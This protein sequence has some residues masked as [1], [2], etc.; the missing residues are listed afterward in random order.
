M[1]RQRYSKKESWNRILRRFQG[2]GVVGD[3]PGTVPGEILSEDE[4]WSDLAELFAGSLPNERVRTPWAEYGEIYVASGTAELGM[5]ENQWENI[6]I[7][8]TAGISSAN[9]TPSPSGNYVN[10]ND[11]G[12]YFVHYQAS[13]YM[14]VEGR[15]LDWRA[16]WNMTGQDQTRSRIYVGTSG[17]VHTVSA[18]GLVDVTANPSYSTYVDLYAWCENATGTL[19]ILDA[20]LSVWK[21]K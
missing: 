2:K 1:T 14:D 6:A 19:H 5:D 10:I 8:T 17:T 3:T 4:A 7:F 16:E 12:A 20:Q 13:F 18:G 9:V 15:T 21:V 11:V